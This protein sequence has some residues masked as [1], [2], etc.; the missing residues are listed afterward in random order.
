MSHLQ[1]QECS[2]NKCSSEY[3]KL[4]KKQPCWG[5]EKHCRKRNYYSYPICPEDSRGWEHTKEKQID[6]F[7]RSADFGMIREFRDEMMH[8]C[9]ADEEGDSTLDCNQ[10]MRYC[11]A[12]NLYMNLKNSRMADSRERFRTDVFKKGEIGGHCQ[13]DGQRLKNSDKQKG[14]LQSW[15]SELRPFTSLKF[16]P[17]IDRHHC[18]V[19]VERPTYFMKLDAGINMF[20]HFCDFVNLYVTQHVNGSFTTDIN[21]VMWDTSSMNY[22]D[23]FTLTW[24]A[25]SRHPV[26]RLSDYDNKRVCFKDAI[27]TLPPRMFYGLYYNMPLIP[28][29]YNSGLMK[30]FSEHVVHRLNITTKPYDP[31]RYRITLLSRSTKYRRILNEDKLIGA[32]KTIWNYDVTRVDYTYQMPFEKQLEITHNSDIFIGMHG[33]GLTHM[34]FQPHWGVAFELYNCEDEG[35]Y[36]DLARLRGVKYLTWEKKKYLIQQDEGHHPTL[37]AHA[38]FTNYA[39]NIGEF[40]R[41]IEKGVKHVAANRPKISADNSVEDSSIKTEL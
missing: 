9:K 11:R 33:S 19:I 31:N 16:K 41:M 34:L 8:L 23:F 21:I 20:H 32:L 10:H 3:K 37:G 4:S 17:V 24:K 35:C 29:C 25:F 30:A 28:G 22:G 12:T 6:K 5:Y 1:R 40:L 2:N 38:K 26:K 14:E 39:F 18:D 36:Y 13:L 15:H 7:W 27:F